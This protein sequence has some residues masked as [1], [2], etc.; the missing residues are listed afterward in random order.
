MG[1]LRQNRLEKGYNKLL[2]PSLSPTSLPLFLRHDSN[3]F[4]CCVLRIVVLK[5]ETEISLYTFVAVAPVNVKSSTINAPSDLQPPV[6]PSLS[7]SSPQPSFKINVQSDSE[8][9][10]SDSDSEDEDDSNNTT[11]VDREAKERA[12]LLV[13]EAAG[14]LIRQED[15]GEGGNP[16]NP[17]RQAPRRPAPSRPSRKDGTS[18]VGPTEIKLETPDEKIERE[19]DA[20][21]VRLVGAYA[22]ES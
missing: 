3:H 19:S 18:K 9:I 16:V 20:Y 5:L 21:D 17:S 6:I 11:P 7:P 8:E 12:R 1:G 2:R 14:V 10:S 4:S 22:S 15:A 13:L